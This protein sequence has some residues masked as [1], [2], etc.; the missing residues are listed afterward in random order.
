MNLEEYTAYRASVSSKDL[1]LADQLWRTLPY[2][3]KH[4]LC[5]KYAPDGNADGQDIVYILRFCPELLN[6]LLNR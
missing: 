5:Q 3:I 4:N 2:T 6:R 1:F